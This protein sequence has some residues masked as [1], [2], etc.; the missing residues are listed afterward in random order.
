MNFPSYYR[1]RLDVLGV[2]RQSAD[3]A[4]QALIRGGVFPPK[5]DKE[6]LISEQLLNHSYSVEPLTF[7]ELTSGNTWFELNPELI[8]GQEVLKTSREFP[9]QI[10]GNRQQIEQVFRTNSVH[11]I[12]IPLIG[13]S[14]KG[15]EP[16]MLS[17]QKGDLRVF[18]E[19]SGND[20]ILIT[21]F[22]A[23][24]VEQSFNATEQTIHQTLHSVFSSLEQTTGNSTELEL[25]ALALEIELQLLNL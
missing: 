13:W 24:G 8:C 6:A 17:F 25:E 1:A 7:V 9:L 4:E 12:P 23:Q 11:W 3:D 14:V 19:A 5:Y 20:T 22:D 16:D 15:M 2:L 18:A 21:A 10:K